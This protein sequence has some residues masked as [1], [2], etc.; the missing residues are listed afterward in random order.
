VLYVMTGNA[1]AAEGPTVTPHSQDERVQDLAAV[2]V[3]VD[4][5]ELLVTL[6]LMMSRFDALERRV[7]LL[8]QQAVHRPGASAEAPRLAG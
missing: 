4:D 1:Q 6:N 5:E 7:E 8:E 2:D 3:P